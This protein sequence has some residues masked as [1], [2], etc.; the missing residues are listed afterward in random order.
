MVPGRLEDSGDLQAFLEVEPVL[1]GLVD[2]EPD[3]DHEVVAHRLSDRLVHHQPEPAA[4]LDRAAEP[5]GAAVGRGRQEL[6]DEV[7]AGQGLD[8]VETA[9]PAPHGGAGVVGDDPLDVVLV[10][11]PGERPVQGLAHRRRPDG[12]EPR[13]GVGLAAAAHVGDLAHQM[14]AAGVDALGESPEVLDDALVVQVDLRE[15]PLGVG[16]DVRRAA[17]HRERDPAP[18]LRLVVPLVTFRGHPALGEA[19]RM[20][21]AH[22]AVA[23]DEMLQRERPKQRVVRDSLRCGRVLGHVG[24]LRS[25]RAGRSA[26]TAA[27]DTVCDRWWCSAGSRRSLPARISSGLLVQS[28]PPKNRSSREGAAP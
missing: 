7:C 15:V 18:G 13:A 4:V 19:A 3:A 16:R 1:A 26:T 11:L 12:R 21:G 8:A 9:F 24:G 20:A 22:D 27:K 17:E 2:H 23:E 6:P 28:R 10:H 14:C 5:V 25:G